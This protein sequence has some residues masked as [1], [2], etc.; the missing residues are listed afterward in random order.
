MFFSL[1][2]ITCQRFIVHYP[3]SGCIVS[4][5]FFTML[6]YKCPQF[7]FSSSPIPHWFLLLLCGYGFGFRGD[8]I[9]ETGFL[10]A[11]ALTVLELTLQTD[12]PGTQEIY[13]PLSSKFGKGMHAP[14]LSSVD[15]FLVSLYLK[16]RNYSYLILL[17]SLIVS[18]NTEYCL[19]SRFS[20]NSTLINDSLVIC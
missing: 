1:S 4:S 7:S 14:P 18:S 8:F 11:T 15:M 16:N 3:T 13:L 19:F 20:G 5:T 6:S 9:F 2:Y 12:W 10:C 17:C